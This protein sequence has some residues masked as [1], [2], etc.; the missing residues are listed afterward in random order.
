MGKMEDYLASISFRNPDNRSPS[1]FQYSMK[2]NMGFFEWL[3]TQP[4]KLEK[5]SATMTVI[6]MLDLDTVVK[7]LATLLGERME[8]DQASDDAL[9]VDVGGGRGKIL[10]NLRKMSPDLKG[11][12]VV[13]DLAGEIAGLEA[14][15]GIETMVH[16]FLTPQPV[17]GKSGNSI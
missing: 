11:R 8:H 10:H 12:M 15:D 2:T 7:S 17:K 16:N 6:T 9:I 1:L 5:F 4:D 13:Q 14:Y 3:H